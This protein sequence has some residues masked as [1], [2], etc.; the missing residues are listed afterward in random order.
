MRYLNKNQ[1]KM[2]RD[3]INS[4]DARRCIEKRFC[5]FQK[6]S[7]YGGSYIPD[8]EHSDELETCRQLHEKGLLTGVPGDLTTE[9]R[10]WF[11]ERDARFLHDL[12]WVGLSAVIAALVAAAFVSIGLPQ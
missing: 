11:E 9:G 10:E 2:L 1:K 6:M 4:G 8:P 3:L 12:F 7:G 5:R